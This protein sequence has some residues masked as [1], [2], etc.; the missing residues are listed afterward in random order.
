MGKYL[1]SIAAKILMIL[2]IVI[3]VLFAIYVVFI[4]QESK[5]RAKQRFDENM[6]IEQNNVN[7][8]FKMWIDDNIRLVKVIANDKRVI[9]ACLEPTNEALRKDASEFLESIFKQSKGLENL[10]IAIKLDNGKTF[11]ITYKNKEIQIHDGNFFMDTAD[12]KTLGKCNP[13]FSY[14]K[15]TYAGEEFYVCKAYPSILRGNPIF[16]IST[17]IKHNGKLIAVAV[18]APQLDYFTDRFIVSRENDGEETKIFF[19]DDRGLIIAD[20]KKEL[21]LNAK[22]KDL[23]VKKILAQKAQNGFLL[24]VSG[25]E[26]YVSYAKLD[27]EN[28]PHENDWFVGVIQPEYV[29][30]QE[31]NSLFKSM[32][33]MVLL[34]VLTIVTVIVVVSRRLISIPFNTLITEIDNFSKGD[35]TKDISQNALTV[36]NEIGKLSISFDKMIKEIRK[37]VSQIGQGSNS[38]ANA[39]AQIASMSQNISQGSNEQAVSIEEVSATIDQM[40]ASIRQNSDNSQHT[41]IIANKA[42]E[43]II[44]GSKAVDETIISIKTIAQKISIISEIAFQTNIL[45]LNAAI[46]AARAS[47]HG[48]GFAVVASEV[49]RLA[50]QSRLAAKEIDELTKHSVNK[51]EETGKMFLEIVPSILNTAELVRQIS[52]SSL[53][54]NKGAQQISMAIQQINQ[55]SQQN[56]ATSEELAT[57][58]EEMSGQAEHLKDAISFFKIKI[59]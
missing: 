1:N 50:E 46:E 36:K 4:Y 12:G 44:K 13:D 27:F 25:K 56:V 53:E 38:V 49:R 30:N 23:D 2:I 40:T 31:A 5:T 45:A 22:Q 48:K 19:F 11:T 42:A 51:A 32:L 57:N 3:S 21:I 10:P 34:F 24:K 52:A 6:R 14:I 39:G 7:L 33:I 43:E 37:I 8:S 9:Q 18:V 47:E 17:Q 54:Q 28:Y 16:V 35:F 26:S 15:N 58:A 29:V 41:E 59:K 55:V 20:A